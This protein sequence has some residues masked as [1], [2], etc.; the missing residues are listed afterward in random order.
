MGRHTFI[1]TL[2]KEGTLS[3]LEKGTLSSLEKAR[4]TFCSNHDDDVDNSKKKE[5][6]MVLFLRNKK[7]FNNDY[8]ETSSSICL[9]CNRID[10]LCC[11]QLWTCFVDLLQCPYSSSYPHLYSNS[12][13]Y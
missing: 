4:Q 12:T 5:A 3:S 10:F 13:N 7:S 2:E 11:S 1:F 6:I 8:M 9:D